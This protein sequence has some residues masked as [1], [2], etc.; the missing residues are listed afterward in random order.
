MSSIQ[1]LE[2]LEKRRTAVGELMAGINE[3]GV[4]YYSSIDSEPHTEQTAER[5]AE[6]TEEAIY[7]DGF[8]SELRAAFR[9]PIEMPNFGV[10]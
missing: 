3:R 7:L 1:H 8:I 10:V 2:Y 4:R 9:G 6:L 5:L